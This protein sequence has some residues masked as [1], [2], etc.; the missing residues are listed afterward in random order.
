MIE[1]LKLTNLVNYLGYINHNEIE[2]YFSQSNVGISYIP[3]TDFFNYQPP[4]KTYEYLM[5]GLI[6]IATKTFEN[7]KVINDKNGILI[8][9][10][11]ESFYNGLVNLQKNIQQFSAK[12]I[13]DSSQ[14]YN[15]E[16]IVSKNLIK[17]LEQI[18]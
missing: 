17:Y 2:Q 12:E 8:E 9:D 18:N 10:N 16:N 3:I 5:S 15:W 7:C 13:Y 11:A 1:E 4:T 6:V 14:Q